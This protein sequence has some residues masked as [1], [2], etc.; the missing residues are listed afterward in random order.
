MR[1]AIAALGAAI[2]FLAA[3]LASPGAAETVTLA[4]PD[5]SFEAR[6]ALLSYDG[7]SYRLA[8]EA[9]GVLTIAA[10]SVTC[11]GPACPAREDYVEVVRLAGT[12]ALAEVAMPALIEA[13][14][15]ERGL[16]WQL[17]ADPVGG[18][19]GARPAGPLRYLLSE[20]P[21]APVALIEVTG[22]PAARAFA[23]L[24]EA[25]TD[26]VL[27]D[28]PVAPAEVEAALAAQVGDLRDP[29]RRRLV[30]RRALRVVTA[31]RSGV[32]PLAV[33]DLFDVMTGRVA[34]WRG[35][36]GPDLPVSVLGL[37]R[38][39]AQ[40]GAGLDAIAAAAARPVPARAAIR[41]LPDPGALTEALLADP[42]AIAVTGVPI[43]AARPVPLSHG[44]VRGSADTSN[45][46][47]DGAAPLVVGLWTYTGA[48]R[49]SDVGR[50]FLIFA[51]SPDAQRVIDRA[52]LVDLRPRPL[53]VAQQGTRLANAIR[54]AGEDVPLE[55]LKR[56][57]AAL[58][59]GER[60]STTFRFTPGTA[61]L[62]FDA[63]SQVATLAHFVD[64]GRFDGRRLLFAG[65]SD[66]QGP[67]AANRRLSSHRASAVRDAVRAAIETD[68][69]R[70]VM[71]ARGFGEAM[72]LA[73]DRD[74][75]GRYVNR[76][77]EVWLAPAP[78]PVATE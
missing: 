11:T 72:P 47:R 73:C 8:T 6:G 31:P 57:L 40:L 29:L 4:F 12:P 34:D 58:S 39:T 67:A 25:R 37:G 38:E 70:V 69:N 5:G 78:V 26:I 77:V 24:T 66:A 55:E 33:E 10:D 65:F 27:S 19:D 54:A 3:P 64:S 61:M 48:R 35:L 22:M 30:A 20:G 59:E 14:A 17:F 18:S 28:R 2:A 63:E 71:E 74:A 50:A 43:F 23:E 36:G 15:S 46:V 32:P 76:R 45:A 42:G 21:E 16:S 13:F 62:D 49:L 52:G 9:F 56:V 75:W 7:R 44:C 1:K 51:T 53:S 60:L 68:P 41:T